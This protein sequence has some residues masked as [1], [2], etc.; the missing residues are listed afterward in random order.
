MPCVTYPA[1]VKTIETIRLENFFR[2]A[3]EVR[4]RDRLSTD[5]A[6]A[7][8]VGISGGYLSQLNSGVRS[9]IESDAARKIERTAEKPT[10][11]MDTNF[12]LWP[13]P[14]RSLLER[15]ERLKIDQRIEVQGAM[16]QALDAIERSSSAL[17]T[18]PPPPSIS[19][20]AAA[21]GKRTLHKNMEPVARRGRARVRKPK[22]KG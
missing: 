19:P 4:L 22:G 17:P 1:V 10:G 3:E 11:W 12:D 20:E 21:K 6:V 16:R 2:L 13:F 15:V 5:K 18:P 8:A 7:A 14:D 9:A